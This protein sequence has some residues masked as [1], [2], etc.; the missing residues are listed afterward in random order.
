[1][2]FS[3]YKIDVYNLDMNL[4]F[5]SKK[6]CKHAQFCHSCKYSRDIQ[7]GLTFLKNYFNVL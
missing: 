4:I 7:S 6:N 1:M 5:H 3:P 2:V